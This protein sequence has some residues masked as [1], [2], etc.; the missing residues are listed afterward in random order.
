MIQVVKIREIA[1]TL[2]DQDKTND[3]TNSEIAQNAKQYIEALIEILTKLDYPSKQAVALHNR[4]S[5]VG[6]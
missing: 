1:A 5:P 3:P 4:I 6:V 2:L